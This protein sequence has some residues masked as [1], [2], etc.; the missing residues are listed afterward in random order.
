M[1]KDLSR[2]ATNSD[3]DQEVRG[4]KLGVLNALV[5]KLVLATLLRRRAYQHDGQAQGARHAAG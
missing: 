3:I 1:I 2:D 5:T 4:M